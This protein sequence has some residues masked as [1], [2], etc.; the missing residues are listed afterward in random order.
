MITNDCN[1]KNKSSS[2][3]GYV[4]KPPNGLKEGSD[5]ARSYLAGAF[6]YKVLEI[7]VF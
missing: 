3:L 5:E 1:L 7:E 6:N 4:F 2:N